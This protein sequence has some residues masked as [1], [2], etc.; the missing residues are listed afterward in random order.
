MIMLSLST[1][2]DRLRSIERRR[3]QGV[4][5]VQEDVQEEIMD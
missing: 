1:F 2:A 3:E 4:D 5:T